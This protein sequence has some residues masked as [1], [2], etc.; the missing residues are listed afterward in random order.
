MMKNIVF[1]L[2]GVVFA[3][4]EARCP[5][6][7]M[8]YFYFINSGEQLPDF[9][10]DYDRGTRS[11][12]NVAQCL[13]QFRGS[14][15]QTARHMMATAI[16]YQDQVAPTAELIA[17]LKGESYR[18]FVLSN[19]SKEYIDFLRKMP[20]YQYFD[21]EVISCEVGLN[22]PEREIYSLLLDKFSLDPLQTMFIDDRKENVVAAAELGIVPFHFDRKNPEQSCNQIRELLKK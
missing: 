16:T 21:G 1:D 9:W 6:E 4:N 14:D 12:D 18:L 3:R 22:K 11:F 10:C 19:M 8:D 17:E 13:A 2:A 15:V 7:L 20:V 5:Q